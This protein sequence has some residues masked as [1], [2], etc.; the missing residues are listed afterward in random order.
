MGSSSCGYINLA[1]VCSVKFD[2]QRPIITRAY[3]YKQEKGRQILS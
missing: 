3:D 1:V 2:V